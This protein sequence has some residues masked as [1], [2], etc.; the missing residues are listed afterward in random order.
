MIISELLVFHSRIHTN[1]YWSILNF[2]GVGRRFYHNWYK[3]QCFEISRKTDDQKISTA[4]KALIYNAM[5]EFDLEES[6]SNF[7]ILEFQSCS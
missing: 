7:I 2:W 6:Y 1:S 5:F 4:A 3:N